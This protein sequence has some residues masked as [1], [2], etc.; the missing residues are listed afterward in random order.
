[1]DVYADEPLADEEWFAEYEKR[2]EEGKQHLEKL[3]CRLDGV[4]SVN[5]W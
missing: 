2:R 5:S 1:M 3:S 4:E